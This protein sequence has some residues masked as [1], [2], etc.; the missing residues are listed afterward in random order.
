MFG[1]DY[2]E[3]RNPFLFQIFL[4][5]HALEVEE[6]H[7]L[8]LKAL[9]QLLRPLTSKIFISRKYRSIFILSVFI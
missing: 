7:L 5:A 1:L 6:L 2:R 9:L 3:V 8:S 4:R